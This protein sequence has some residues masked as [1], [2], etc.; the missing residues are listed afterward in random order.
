MGKT[1]SWNNSDLDPKAVA[2]PCGIMA[3]SLF[4]GNFLII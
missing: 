4:T 3:K 2:S 1:K